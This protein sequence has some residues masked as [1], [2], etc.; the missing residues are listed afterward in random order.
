MALFECWPDTKLLDAKQKT[1]GESF[2]GLKLSDATL[3]KFL[4]REMERNGCRC[5]NEIYSKVTDQFGVY[6]DA[7]VLARQQMLFA[8]RLLER[9]P[10]PISTPTDPTEIAASLLRQMNPDLDSIFYRFPI[11][12]QSEKWKRSDKTSR[13]D[14]ETGV[15]LILQKAL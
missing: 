5:N 6:S 7:S 4:L 8:P 2:W 3:A 12:A 15:M 14:F 13:G 10:F 11:V 1:A 9:N